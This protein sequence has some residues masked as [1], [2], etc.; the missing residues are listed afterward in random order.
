MFT[1]RA[2][3]GVMNARVAALCSSC[4]L[5]QIISNSDGQLWMK[6][7]DQRELM[8]MR[9]P[10]SRELNSIL[11]TCNSIIHYSCTVNWM[12]ELLRVCAACSLNLRFELRPS[13]NDIHDTFP[14]GTMQDTTT[15]LPEEYFLRTWPYYLVFPPI[16]AQWEIKWINSWTTIKL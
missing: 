14:T 1:T 6:L 9:D 15:H 2:I 4:S 16:L 12:W 10:R 8:L 3:C 5:Q 13:W 7:D 11:F